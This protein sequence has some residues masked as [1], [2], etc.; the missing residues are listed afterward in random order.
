M[1]TM[2]I[3]GRDYA[4]VQDRLAE[5]HKAHGELSII[6]EMTIIDTE[7]NIFSFKASVITAKGEFTGH[8]LKS[9]K[10]PKDF[11]KAETIAVGRALAMAGYISVGA[12]ASYDEVEDSLKQKAYETVQ[13]WPTVKIPQNTQWKN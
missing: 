9:L 6:T 4:K 5:A 11:E 1:E 3:Q 8:S 13:E 10:A 2:K 7:K 12:I